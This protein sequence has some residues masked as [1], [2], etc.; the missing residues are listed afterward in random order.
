VPKVVDAYTTLA[1][2]LAK[3]ILRAEPADGAGWGL[4]TTICSLPLWGG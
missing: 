1:R 3:P 2:P 4:N